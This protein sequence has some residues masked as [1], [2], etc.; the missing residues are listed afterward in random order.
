MHEELDRLFAKIPITAG[1][2]ESTAL[3]IIGV[4]G[5]SIET[6]KDLVS[7]GHNIASVGGRE[8]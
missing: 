6:Y 3:E 2:I 7:I 8:Y 5:S 1:F 4:F